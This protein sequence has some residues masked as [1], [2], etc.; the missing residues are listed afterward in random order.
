MVGQTLWLRFRKTL[1]PTA[2]KRRRRGATIPNRSK[3]PRP[4][5][6]RATCPDRQMAALAA[7]AARSLL[8]GPFLPPMSRMPAA[9]ARRST[10]M[11]LRRSRRRMQMRTRAVQHPG[12]TP[13]TVKAAAALLVQKLAR[14][15]CTP[16]K[17]LTTRR[18]TMAQLAC[19]EMGRTSESP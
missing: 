13:A 2:R 12:A 6:R 19:T 4:A 10:M 8:G 1:G 14:G 18:R 9:A 7:A 3:R 17:A 16:G 5:R 15:N 11:I